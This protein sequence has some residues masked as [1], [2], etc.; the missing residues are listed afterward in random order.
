MPQGKHMYQNKALHFKTSVEWRKWLQNNHDKATEAWLVIYKK[1]SSQ[2]GLRYEEALEEALCFGWID[3]KMKSID[4]DTFILRYSPRN[5][6]SIWSQQN[7]EKTEQLIASGKMTQAGLARVE[8]AKMNGTWEK[9]YTQK[10]KD[11]IPA[12]L[13]AAL[14]QN[15]IA[16]ANFNKFANSYRNMYILW[17]SS[18]KTKETR[19]KR[20]SEVVERSEL[21]KKSWT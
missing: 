6:R 18:A 17:V 20:I 21:N 14:S 19:K 2:T 7:R 3:G 5:V 1:R 16:L 8:E 12:D 11:E 4:K 15:Q 9:A 10:K 13:E